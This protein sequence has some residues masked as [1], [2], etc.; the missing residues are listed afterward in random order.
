MP[1]INCKSAREGG[2]ADDH[3]RHA[4][5]AGRRAVAVTLR[6]LRHMAETCKRVPD[7]VVPAPSVTSGG[8]RCP[9][10]WRSS[11]ICGAD[12][13][14]S[15][16]EAAPMRFGSNETGRRRTT[17]SSPGSG[18]VAKRASCRPLGYQVQ[19]S[20][21]IPDRGSE[22]RRCRSRPASLRRRRDRWKTGSRSPPVRG[23]LQTNA[24]G[25]APRR[26]HRALQRGIGGADRRAIVALAEAVELIITT[27]NWLHCHAR[28][29]APN[30]RRPTPK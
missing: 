20:G 6:Q 11:S 25:G 23:L 5:R 14:E 18:L 17:A 24:A 21:N 7:I 3:V 15:A 29:R 8:V 27:L 13:D 30:H 22:Q 26:H 28:R 16:L 4:H 9:Y 10:R 2:L 1:L 12:S 19:V